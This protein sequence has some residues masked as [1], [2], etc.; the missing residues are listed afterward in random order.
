MCLGRLSNMEAGYIVWNNDL[1]EI[2]TPSIIGDIDMALYI[3]DK[4]NRALWVQN[5]NGEYEGDKPC[6]YVVKSVTLKDVGEDGKE[7]G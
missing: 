5:E 7:I 4:Y 3:A 6:R 2:Y 1:S